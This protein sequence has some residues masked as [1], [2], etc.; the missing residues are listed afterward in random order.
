V[1]LGKWNELTRVEFDKNDET[2]QAKTERNEMPGVQRH[3]CLAGRS[4]AVRAQDLPATLP[5]VRR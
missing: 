1:I 2:S 4:A 3:R 5:R